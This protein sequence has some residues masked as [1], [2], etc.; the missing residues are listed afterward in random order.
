M[1]SGFEKEMCAGLNKQ[2]VEYETASEWSGRQ[3]TQAVIKKNNIG[4]DFK[5][6]KV[7]NSLNT[8]ENLRNIM[9]KETSEM[10]ISTGNLEGELGVD[11][12][13]RGDEMNLLF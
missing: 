8:A 1:R 5:E 10:T 3:E 12:W 11:S 2:N 7:V 13:L 4:Q 6:E 9:N